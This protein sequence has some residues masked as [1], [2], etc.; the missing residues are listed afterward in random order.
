[1]V[2][3]S[4]FWSQQLVLDE[5]SRLCG[6]CRVH[7]RLPQVPVLSSVSNTHFPLPFLNIHFIFHSFHWHVQ[8]A[9]VPCRSQEL[10]PFLSVIPVYHFLTSFS[11]NYSSIL[12]HFILSSSSCSTSQSYCFRIHIPWC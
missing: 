8:N 2:K 4:H 5:N 3:K 6:V 11:T 7:T 9:T 1:M 10:L 12:P